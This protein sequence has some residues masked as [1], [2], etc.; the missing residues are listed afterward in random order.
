MSFS[1]YGE[2]LIY[3]DYNMIKYKDKHVFATFQTYYKS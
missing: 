3:Q 2:K 1:S